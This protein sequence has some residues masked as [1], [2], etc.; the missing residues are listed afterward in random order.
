M[1]DK[2]Q[3]KQTASL[4]PNANDP[5]VVQTSDRVENNT[6]TDNDQRTRDMG[7]VVAKDS[8]AQDGVKQTP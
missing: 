6:K 2:K 7:D 1:A 5:K 8:A 4:E 3:D